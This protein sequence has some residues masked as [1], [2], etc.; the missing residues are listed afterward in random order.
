MD[1]ELTFVDGL[2]RL[3]VDRVDLAITR[4]LDL[5]FHLHGFEDQDDIAAVADLSGFDVNT[6][7][8]PRH[9]R[10]KTSFVWF[11]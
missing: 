4:R 11:G 7:D 8:R 3:D 2:A 5:V 10:E 6:Q 9:K 1:Q